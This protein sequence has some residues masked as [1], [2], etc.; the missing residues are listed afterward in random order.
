MPVVKLDSFLTA[1]VI[2]GRIEMVEMAEDGAR[3]GGRVGGGRGRCL[4]T[5][6]HMS[7]SALIAG[8]GL[9]P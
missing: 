1:D 5:E 8:H 7:E 2:N 9:F 4:L 6:L 3:D